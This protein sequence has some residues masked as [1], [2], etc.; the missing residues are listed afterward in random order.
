VVFSSEGT[1][2]MSSS[3]VWTHFSNYLLALRVFCSQATHRGC[4][5]GRDDRCWRPFFDT[6]CYC[7]EFCERRATPD[8]CPDF[9]R[10]CVGRA[11]YYQARRLDGVPRKSRAVHDE[12]LH[13]N[14]DTAASCKSLS[15]FNCMVVD[16]QLATID[17]R[18]PYK[19]Q[20]F[21]QK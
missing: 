15:I 5:F 21:K 17:D 9:R 20:S 16:E 18:P 19:G 2:V 7:D 11:R 14:N 13:G 6:T 8:C 4:C 12:E 1:T 10:H 3:P